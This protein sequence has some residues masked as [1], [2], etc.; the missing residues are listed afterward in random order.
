MQDGQ[1]GHLQG[2]HHPDVPA[3]LPGQRIAA[4]TLFPFGNPSSK[5]AQT[6]NRQHTHKHS[7]E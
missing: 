4:G 5:S 1:T 2:I 3:C 7:N 6:K